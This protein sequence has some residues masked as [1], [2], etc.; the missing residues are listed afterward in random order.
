MERY[1]PQERG[2]IVS[3]FLCNNSSVVLAQREFRRRFPGRPAPTAQTLRRLA[4]N[5]EEYGTTRDVAKSG[6]PRS[7][8][9]AENIAAVAEDVELSPET[10]TRRR[11]S[12]LAISDP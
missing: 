4:T 2:I 6:R 9:S 8:R 1:T 11:A 7:P 5:L 12:Q 10:S 3:I